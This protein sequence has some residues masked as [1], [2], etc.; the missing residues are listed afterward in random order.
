[1]V[2][3]S[4][5]AFLLATAQAP[6]Y[7]ASASYIVTP[8]VANQEQSYRDSVYGIDALSRRSTVATYAEIFSSARV[9]DL[10]AAHV[11][12]PLENRGNYSYQAV[13]LPETS[14]IRISA[15]GSDPLVVCAV[16]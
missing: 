1:M 3:A 14:I 16:L 15:V 5:A 6:R 12:I 4:C 9:F 8:N 7:R 2:I 11:N 10:A 13:V